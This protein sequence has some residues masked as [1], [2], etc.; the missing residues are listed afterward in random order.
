MQGVR[1]QEPPL[2]LCV[3]SLAAPFPLVSARVGVGCFGEESPALGV[4]R[5]LKMR[6]GA[7]EQRGREK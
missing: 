6:D 3:P 7:K 4:G 1:P 5:P 2:L